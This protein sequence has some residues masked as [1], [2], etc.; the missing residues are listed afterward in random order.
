[1]N[2]NLI[3]IPWSQVCSVDLIT[4]SILIVNININRY[5]GNEN[6]KDIF[7]NANLDVFIMNCHASRLK[8]LIDERMKFNA[9]RDNMVELTALDKLQ[10]KRHDIECVRPVDEEGCIPETDE[11]SL[12]SLLVSD[13]DKDAVILEDRIVELDALYTYHNESNNSNKNHMKVII[14]EEKSVIM[15]RVCRLRLYISMLLGESINGEHDFSEEL[16]NQIMINDFKTSLFIQHDDE[17]STAS[18]RVEY[19][20]DTAEKRCRDAALRGWSHQGGV[21]EKC[22][23]MFVNGYFVEMI[24]QIAKFFEGNI[25]KNTQLLQGL[26]SKVK[27]ITFF[28]TENDRLSTLLQSSLRPYDMIAFPEPQFSLFLGIYLSIYLLIYLSLYLSY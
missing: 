17:I 14:M 11:L 21:L 28:M 16:I 23:E 5:F 27:L 18:N 8:S 15:R 25:A 6:N 22:I 13:L 19:L 7:R 3:L 12:G 26:S 20:I 24:G 1:M 9:F 4:P 2:S 10:L